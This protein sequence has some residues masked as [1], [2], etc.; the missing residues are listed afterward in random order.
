MWT[1]E[2]LIKK[3]NEYLRIAEQFK[4]DAIANEGA[5]KAIEYLIL[6]LE[7]REIGIN[8]KENKA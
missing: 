3:K 5:A 6:D 7:K 2:D 1:K 8:D 4:N